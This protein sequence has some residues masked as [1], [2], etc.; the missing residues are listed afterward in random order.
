MV[1]SMHVNWLQLFAYNLLLSFDVILNDPFVK[2]Y[3]EKGKFSPF[4]I[5]F[6]LMKNPD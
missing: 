3:I 1:N 6:I 5:Y 4:I 2:I